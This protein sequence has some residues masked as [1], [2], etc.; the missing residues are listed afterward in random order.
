MA[1]DLTGTAHLHFVTLAD[2]VL[3]SSLWTGL[4]GM[5]G[6]GVCVGCEVKC[7]GVSEELFCAEVLVQLLC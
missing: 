6:R 2:S 3:Y 5:E 7:E 4:A 1:V